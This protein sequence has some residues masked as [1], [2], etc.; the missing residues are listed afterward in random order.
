[1]SGY[2][3]V[4]V[5]DTLPE[6]VLLGNDIN[7]KAFVTTRAQLREENKQV[8]RAGNFFEKSKIKPT[9]DTTFY[10]TIHYSKRTVHSLFVQCFYFQLI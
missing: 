1:M 10:T 2:Y 6:N 9:G 7:S 4:G 3:E 8:Q 5:V